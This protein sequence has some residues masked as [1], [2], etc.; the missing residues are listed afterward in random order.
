M[1]FGTKTWTRAQVSRIMGRNRL[2]VRLESMAGSW[3]E[4]SLAGD[5]G[6]TR[7]TRSDWGLEGEAD[8]RVAK[9]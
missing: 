8:D 6:P 2:E 1:R 7:A 9:S 4:E 3:L 5:V